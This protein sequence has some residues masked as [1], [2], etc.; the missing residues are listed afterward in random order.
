MKTITL[1]ILDDKVLR[2][3]K[4]LE[5]LKIIRLHHEKGSNKKLG[6]SFISKYKG[7]MT[8]EPLSEIDKKLTELREG[9]E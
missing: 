2:L 1:E 7:A 3:L 5:L 8:T 9:W 6:K 4:D